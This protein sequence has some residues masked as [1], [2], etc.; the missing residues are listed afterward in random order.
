MYDCWIKQARRYKTFL[1]N[2]SHMK[3]HTNLDNY[4]YIV[5]SSTGVSL[6]AYTIRCMIVVDYTHIHT[7]GLFFNIVF[8][9]LHIL[10]ELH[11][12]K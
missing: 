2:L 9:D 11:I 3:H 4:M 12:C 8:T 10:F 5:Q 7:F 1:L 6:D